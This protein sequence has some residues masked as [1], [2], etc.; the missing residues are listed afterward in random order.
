[1]KKALFLLILILFSIHTNSQVV[2]DEDINSWIDSKFELALNSKGIVGA[3][4][5]LVQGDSI[6]H[7]GGYGIENI[8]TKSSI[9]P[10]NSVFTVASISKTFVATA[11]MQLYE[12]GKVEL[13]IDVNSYLTSLQIQYPFGK[14]VTLRHLLTHTGG[15]D[16]RNLAVKVHTK[17]EL[18]S[19]KEHL[20]TRMP[21]QIRAAGEAF[22]YSNYGYALLGLVVE[23]V[24][25]SPFTDYVSTHITEPLQMELSGFDHNAKAESQMVTSYLQKN[26][27]LTGYGKYYSLNYPAG[28]FHSTALDMSHYLRMY[29]NDG[30]FQNRQI[31]QPSTIETMWKD[32]YQN[33]KESYNGWGLGYE[34]YT[35]RGKKIMG[36][37][38]DILGFATDMRFIPEDDIGIYMAFNS[39]SIPGSVSKQFLESFWYQLR[40]K[41]YPD[42]AITKVK[43]PERGTSSLSLEE[44]EGTYRFTRYAQTTLDKLAV[45]IGFAPEI[46]IK[47]ES[48]LLRIIEWD[49]AFYSVKDDSFYAPDRERFVSF[50]KNHEGEISYFFNSSLESYHKLRWYETVQFQMTIIGIVLFI[51]IVVIIR[52]LVL[53]FRKTQPQRITKLHALIAVLILLFL[54]VVGYSMATT[55]PQEFLYGVPDTIEWA[56]YLPFIIIALIIITIVL[57][58]KQNVLKRSSCFNLI[59]TF[60]FI[61][62]VWWLNHWNL[63]GFNY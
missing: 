20:Q 1:M 52:F 46:Q 36:H 4:I 24:S 50:G 3:T 9:N 61:G 2:I 5:V 26:G 60:L 42:L 18:I 32:V 21:P 8:T 44:Y 49:V 37:G 34:M 57:L 11:I 47:K 59:V 27:S 40:Q 7:K 22:D 56:L 62:F 30:A 13:D 15:F 28:G 16:E 43:V 23:N 14:P 45:F 35:W 51:S 41:M 63:I 54:G 31:L 12:Q 48:D 39:S 33:Q 58:F 29:L 25:G 10:D 38:G 53:F 6:I 19:L 55:D 17:E